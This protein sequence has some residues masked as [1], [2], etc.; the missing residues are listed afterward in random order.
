MA[1]KTDKTVGTCTNSGKCTAKPAPGLFHA[2]IGLTG[3][4]K[5]TAANNKVQWYFQTQTSYPAQRP[6]PHGAKFH[7]WHCR[8]AANVFA[9][10]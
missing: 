4:I 5:K 10:P 2:D 9:K 8:G 6:V 1:Y 7:P 3:Q